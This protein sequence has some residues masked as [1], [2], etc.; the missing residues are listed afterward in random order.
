MITLTKLYLVSLPL[1]E[2]LSKMGIWQT[3]RNPCILKK[4][5]TSKIKLLAGNRV[6]NAEKPQGSREVCVV[7]GASGALHT[8]SPDQ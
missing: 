7:T 8:A 1:S 5:V 2:W 4:N 3:N 6:Q